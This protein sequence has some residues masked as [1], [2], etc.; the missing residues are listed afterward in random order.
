M[1]EVEVSICCTVYNHEK[2]L[3]RCLEGFLMQKTD[4]AFEILIH[5]DAST[6][7]SAE[8]IRMYEERYPDIIKPIY[9]IENQYSKGVKISLV[10]QFP[11][12]RGKYIALC[13]GDDFWCDE[14]K[15]QI[16]YDEMEKNKAAVFCVHDVGTA[17]EAG[18]LLEEKFPK[19]V[20]EKI[21]SSNRM[22]NV[23]EENNMYP[24]QTSSYFIVSKYVKNLYK[25]IPKFMQISNVGDVPLMLYLLTKGE[26]IYINKKMSYYRW[27]SEYGWNTLFRN[28]DSK[29]IMQLENGIASYCLYDVY[30]EG[31][32]ADIIE[33]IILYDWFQALILGGNY[34]KINNKIF[35][36]CYKKVDFKRRVYLRLCGIF[37]FFEKLYFSYKKL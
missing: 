30:T 29:R 4:F 18:N 19:T 26:T 22:M 27:G 9:Q 6:D 7:K 5:D 8:I 13:E 34:K 32:Y 12:A 28:T 3:K 11:R 35:R 20:I 37:P 21:I 24:F 16:Q 33:N 10:H 23:L 2:Y 14:N 17:S 36:R 1:N 15:L 25:D 31:K